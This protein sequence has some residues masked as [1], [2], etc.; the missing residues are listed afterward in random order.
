MNNRLYSLRLDDDVFM[1][2]L[3][4]EQDAR[5]STANLRNFLLVSLSSC[6]PSWVSSRISLPFS[7]KARDIAIA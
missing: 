6:R 5:H 3:C 2:L 1:P 7:M 4:L